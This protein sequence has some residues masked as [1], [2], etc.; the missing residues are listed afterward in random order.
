MWSLQDFVHLKGV[1]KKPA[2]VA[3]FTRGTGQSTSFSS[4]NNLIFRATNYIQIH[5]KG[6]GFP[7]QA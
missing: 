7:L 5:V 2:A 3:R 4:N 1:F 6:K